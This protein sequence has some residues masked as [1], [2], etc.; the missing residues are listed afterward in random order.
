MSIENLRTEIAQTKIQSLASN[1]SKCRALYVA[2]FFCL[3]T[4][5]LFTCGALSHS[6]SYHYAG[7]GTT[8]PTLICFVVAAVYSSKER[9]EIAIYQHLQEKL[10]IPEAIELV[11]RTEFRRRNIIST[12]NLARNCGTLLNAQDHLL[13]RFRLSDQVDELDTLPFPNQFMEAL[14][15]RDAT[16]ASGLGNCF[17]LSTVALFDLMEIIDRRKKIEIYALAGGNHVFVVIGRDPTSDPAKFETWGDEAWVYDPWCSE[18]DAPPV[19]FPASLI[20]S[21][22]K[23]YSGTDATRKPILENFDPKRHTLNLHVGNMTTALEVRAMTLARSHDADFKK[24]IED[25]SAYE[26]ASKSE[27]LECARDVERQTEKILNEHHFTRY[28]KRIKDSLSL[29]YSQICYF[30]KKNKGHVQRAARYAL[31]IESAPMPGAV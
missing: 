5:A 27:E 23:N 3:M 16:L 22:L 19:C 15:S 31:E 28:E 11:H 24:L 25:V 14:H 6:V 21:H 13:L 9:M 4:I 26:N 20:P 2:L 8:I 10:R 12:N 29:L 1:R 18:F 17:Q 30:I 7:I